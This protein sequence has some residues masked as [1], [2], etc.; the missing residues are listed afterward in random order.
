MKHEKIFYLIVLLF[1]TLTMAS[2]S[3]NDN[4]VEE[5][6]NWK[7]KNEVY[8]NTLYATTQQKI[9]SGDT[10]WKIIPNFSLQLPEKNITL[11]PENNI[12]VEVLKEGK[13]SGCPIYTDNVRCHYM[14]RLLP[15]TSYADGL[16][17]DKSYYG[18]FNEAT[19]N[20]ATFT[21]NGGLVD[22]FATAMQNMHIGDKW[23]VYIPYQ[24]GYG[25]KGAK[26]IPAYST[27]IFEIILVS[28]YRADAD[29]PNVN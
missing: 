5:Y 8:F 6:P 26:T 14:G 22:G 12:I 16:V 11:K 29:V 4:T 10:S 18:T 27:L 9:A 3:E 20:P 28:Y 7:A 15:S 13:G 17:F 19:A 23:R 2:C 21:I 25:K 1:M 24:L